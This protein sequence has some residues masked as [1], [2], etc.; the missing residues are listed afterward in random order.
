MERVRLRFDGWIAGVGTESG[1]RIVVGHWT[2][3]PFGAFSDVMV[4]QADG[5]RLL[6]VPTGQIGE[7]VAGTYSFDQVDVVPVAVAR[8]GTGWSVTAGPLTLRFTLGR[9]GPLG[10]LL[11]AVPAPLSCR[12]AWAALTDVPSSLLPGVRTRG[13]AG[14]GRREWYAAR[15]LWPITAATAVHRGRDLG[16]LRPVE[17]PV[18]FGFGSTPRTPCQVRITTTV[19][20]D[21]VPR[22]PPSG[23]R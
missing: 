15:D 14:Q 10:W 20:Q 13:S 4:E 23:G 12:P 3:S 18:R 5:F 6:L 2:A 19:E 17:P 1:T 8:T 16:S 9:R 21:G 7:F 11:R 22:R